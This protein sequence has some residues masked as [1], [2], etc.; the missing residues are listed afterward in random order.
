MSILD[1][2]KEW[3]IKCHRET[4]HKYDNMDYDY[5]L[6]MVFNMGKKF[7]HLIP[8]TAR[9]YV[10]AACWCHDI[11]EDA[12]QTYN[13]V[14]KNTNYYVAEISYALTNEKGKTRKERANDKY[15]E[16]IRSVEFATFVKLCDRI[17][18]INHSMSSR[19]NMLDVYKKES[20]DFKRKLYDERYQEMF[21]YIDSMVGIKNEELN[22]A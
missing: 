19:S 16:G 20:Y 6:E 18:N 10:L 11:I 21:D 1:K 17:A 15:Y 9:E 12:R 4:N 7:I 5:H 22:K 8:E 13:D 2:S 3:A 14:V